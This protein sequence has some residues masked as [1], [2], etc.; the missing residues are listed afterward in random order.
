MAYRTMEHWALERYMWLLIYSLG[1]GWLGTHS[2]IP[3]T[4]AID[5]TQNHILRQGIM[6]FPIASTKIILGSPLSSAA[7]HTDQIQR[8][9]NLMK[10]IHDAPF[11]ISQMVNDANGQCA[12]G[13]F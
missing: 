7:F 8:S 13:H 4:T 2:L 12:W 3:F 11:R 5:S 6:A 1:V 9:L 10:I